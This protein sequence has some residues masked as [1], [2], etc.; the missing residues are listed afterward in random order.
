VFQLPFYWMFLSPLRF[1]LLG[2][3]S[4]LLINCDKP[5][6]MEDLYS[7]NLTLPNGQVIRTEVMIDPVSMTRGMM[8]RNSLEPDHGMLFVHKTPGRYSYWMYQTLIPLDIIW[9]DTNHRI[10]EISPKTPPCPSKSAKECPSYGGSKTAN[11]VLE[12]AGGMAAKYGLQ[13]GDSV[14]F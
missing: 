6:R 10:V 2:V 4:L 13:V 8:F 14:A 5:S 1:A 11:F 9:M 7:R 12:L 3:T